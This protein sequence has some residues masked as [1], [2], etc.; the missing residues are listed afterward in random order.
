[1]SAP[2][3]LERATAHAADVD[4]ADLYPPTV[5]RVSEPELAALYSVEDRRYSGEWRVVAEFADPDVANRVAALL[6]SAGGDVRVEF[7]PQ[8]LIP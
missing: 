5:E 8:P 7:I 4:P 2:D 3:P 6:R 1:M